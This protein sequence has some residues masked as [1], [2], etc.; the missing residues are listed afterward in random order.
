MLRARYVRLQH[1]GAAVLNV[2]QIQVFG[3]VHVEPHQYPQDVCDPNRSDN[4]F[5]V[6]MWNP[7]TSGWANIESRGEILWNGSGDMA[8]CSNFSGMQRW[9]IWADLFVGSPA[10][11][12]WNLSQEGGTYSGD[13]SGFESSN[14]V[15]AEFDIQAGFIANVQAGA[16]YEYSFGVTEEVQTL[17]YWGAGLE[18]GGT[19]GGFAPQFSNLVSTCRYTPR[20]YAYRLMDYSNTGYE[21]T[22]FVVDY[23]VRQGAAQWQRDNVPEVCLNI[24]RPPEI[25]AN[26]FE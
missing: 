2:A 7:Q 13:Y 25:F 12:S 8:G 18:M 10:S 4:T 24:Q 11:S 9:N 3:D 16:A 19:I 6:R 17:Q 23:V 1:P 20:P 14:R 21:H 5:L 15:G 26:G 22:V